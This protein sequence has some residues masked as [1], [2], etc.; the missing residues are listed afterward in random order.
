VRGLSGFHV[1]RH[2]IYVIVCC[3]RI[4]YFVVITFTV[5]LLVRG[6]CGLRARCIV[7]SLAAC[8]A[9]PGSVCIMISSV[10]VC[11]AFIC[12]SVVITF[13]VLFLARGLCGLRASCI[14]CSFAVCG[15]FPGS[16]LIIVVL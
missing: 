8:G 6:L 14:D 10:I 12:Y 16:V 4:C 5:L 15:A 2:V 9:F 1:H 3:A 11:S 7:C 13:A